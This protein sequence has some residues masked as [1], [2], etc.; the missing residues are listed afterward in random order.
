M[1]SN[2][3]EQWYFGAKGVPTATAKVPTHPMTRRIGP[4][5]TSHVK[6][7][8][9]NS[10]KILD[11][12]MMHRDRVPVEKVN[13]EATKMLKDAKQGKPVDPTQIATMDKT[14]KPYLP[15]LKEKKL[16]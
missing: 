10:K 1:H 9:D 6:Q 2:S 8:L 15:L 4:K 14:L 7:I 11:I 3:L 16:F 13:V 12:Y 5:E